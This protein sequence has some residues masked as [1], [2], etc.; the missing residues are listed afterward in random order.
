MLGLHLELED[1]S[2]GLLNDV[3]LIRLGSRVLVSP[4]PGQ[5]S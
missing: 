1:R 3:A 5:A 4:A 2:F